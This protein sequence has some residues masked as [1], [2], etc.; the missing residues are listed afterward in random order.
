MCA[1]SVARAVKSSDQRSAL[2]PFIQQQE[3]PMQSKSLNRGAFTG[4]H[5]LAGAIAFVVATTAATQSASA[6]SRGQTVLSLR[7]ASEAAAPAASVI[8]ETPFQRFVELPCTG[9]YCRATLPAVVPTERLV[10][11]FV[12]CNAVMTVAGA[13]R[14]F[15]VSVTDPKLTRLFG[16]HYIAPTY[17]SSGAI[18][19][20]VASQPMLLTV[21][22]SRV[23]NFE[24]NSSTGDIISAACGVSGVRQ[25][26]G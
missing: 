4:S 18:I 1:L 19:H 22:A 10:I 15:D 14:N 2:T 7:A 23:L 8:S 26:L 16:G 11:Q 9:S 6:E 20:Y 12:S 5:V 3:Y 25:K 17:E 24:T 13:L 21:E